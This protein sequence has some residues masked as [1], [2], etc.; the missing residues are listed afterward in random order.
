MLRFSKTAEV[1]GGLAAHVDG[2]TRPESAH[3]RD[4]LEPVILLGP[5]GAVLSMDDATRLLHEAATYAADCAEGPGRS[6]RGRKPQ[7]CGEF[8][9]GGLP[10]YQKTAEWGALIERVASLDPWDVPQ[11]DTAEYRQLQERI[12]LAYT[13]DALEWLLRAAGPGSTLAQCGIHQDEGAPHAH[14]RIVMADSRGRLGWNRVRPGFMPGLESPDDLRRRKGMS[15]MQNFFHEAVA[16]SWG[17]ERGEAGGHHAPIDRDKAIEQRIEEEVAIERI[18]AA[19][20]LERLRR[21][22]RGAR[23]GLRDR[24]AAVE[25]QC[26]A[27]TTR[28]TEAEAAVEAARDEALEQVTQAQARAAS[29]E[30]AADERVAASEVAMAAVVAEQV[31]GAVA[32]VWRDEVAPER[33][34]AAAVER[35]RDHATH[36]ATAAE[37]KVAVLK[38]ERDHA[39]AASAAAEQTATAAVAERDQATARA[40]AAERERDHATHKAT[41]A[42]SKVAVLKQERDQAE[43]ARVE[44]V[45]RAD[46][47]AIEVGRLRRLVDRIVEWIENRLPGLQLGCTEQDE[48]EILAAPD[49]AQVRWDDLQAAGG[50]AGPEDVIAHL[51]AEL[52]VE[53]RKT[54][55]AVDDALLKG[56]LGTTAQTEYRMVRRALAAEPYGGHVVGDDVVGDIPDDIVALT[57][58]IQ[59]VQQERERMVAA[60]REHPRGFVRE[61]LGTIDAHYDAQWVAHRLEGGGRPAGDERGGGRDQG[62][63]QLPGGRGRSP[64]SMHYTQSPPPAVSP[65]PARSTRTTTTERPS[66]PSW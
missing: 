51:Q 43:Q 7:A 61:V 62:C 58:L 30:R 1:R 65:D 38:Q 50:A 27:A 3:P 47:Q 48:V 18:R 14:G 8:M 17:M 57:D 53:F 55:R 12:T 20:R 33:Q 22:A 35:E 32:R 23:D 13:R 29:A 40:T 37:S 19:R 44:A 31:D 10:A 2:R 26:S 11:I 59:K 36:K 41:A 60:A 9:I 5:D 15:A 21:G 34:R 52:V 56:P 6:T 64:Q 39:T 4:H 24:V 63:Q 54:N 46:A 45:G 42:E 28:A 16:A 25:L 66:G 49:P